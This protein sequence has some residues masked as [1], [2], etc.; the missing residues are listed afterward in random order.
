MMFNMRNLISLVEGFLPKSNLPQDEAANQIK[1]WFLKHGLEDTS[2]HNLASAV[3]VNVVPV[4]YIRVDVRDW[5]KGNV[6]GL[7]VYGESLEKA[8]QAYVETL[9]WHVTKQAMRGGYSEFGSVGEI[10]IQPNF[11]A[12]INVPRFVSHFTPEQN[13]TTILQNG[14]EPRSQ[15]PGDRYPPRVYL[16]VRTNTDRD[17]EFI[18]SL[19]AH[20]DPNTKWIE[21][22]VDTAKVPDATYHQDPEAPVGVW[23]YSAI[24]PEAITVKGVETTESAIVE[25]ASSKGRS[26]FQQYGGKVFTY[27]ELPAPGKRAIKQ[28]F[29]DEAGANVPATAKF[30][31]ALIPTEALAAAIGGGSDGDWPD[32]P[33]YHQWYLDQ[34][35]MPD[36][37]KQAFAVILDA[38][39]DEVIWDGWHRFHDYVRKGFKTIPCVLPMKR[40][41]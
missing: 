38:D 32:F 17:F 26:L 2:D 24:P 6:N 21:L 41:D 37:T 22:M 40:E 31:Y 20:A 14:L 28:Y 3:T 35:H 19:K 29:V 33:T 23:T 9:G 7:T 16:F 13:V 36:Y 30:G 18:E 12:E 27:R 25:E 15:R 8:F 10:T 1:G 4:G 34:G 5:P 39:D 11:T